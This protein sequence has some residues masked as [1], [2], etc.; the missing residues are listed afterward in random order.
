MGIK[1]IIKVPLFS[2]RSNA[3]LRATARMGR[4]RMFSPVVWVALSGGINSPN[5]FIL[6]YDPQGGRLSRGRKRQSEPEGGTLAGQAFH[7]NLTVMALNDGPADEQPQPQAHAGAAADLDPWYTVKA[8]PE[9]LLL[10]LRNAW[11]VI[12]HPEAHHAFLQHRAKLNRLIFS[13]IFQRVGQIIGHN[14][15]DA[16]GI[17]VNG[18]TLVARQMHLNGALGVG[19]ALLLHHFADDGRQIGRFRAESE[20]IGLDA[21]D[22][23]EVVDQAIQAARL[24]AGAGK[25][26]FKRLQLLA[27]S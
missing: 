10:G 17:G 15:L 21:R 2:S 6:N 11:P 22:I 13:G 1:S 4:R 12:S 20:L 23:Q 26:L 9:M 19:L 24:A 3:S 7:T 5:A 18:H 25:L 27:C 14:L 16:P 8:L